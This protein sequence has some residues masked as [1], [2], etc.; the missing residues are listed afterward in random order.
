VASAALALAWSRYLSDLA[1]REGD[2]ELATRA[3]R[4]GEASRQSLLTAFEL[5]AREAQA[6]AATKPTSAHG[7]LAAVLGEGE[8]Q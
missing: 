7:A 1:A 2:P 8:R 3:V 6:R 4:M 5:C